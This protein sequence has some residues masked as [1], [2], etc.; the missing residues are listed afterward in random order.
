MLDVTISDT[1][2]KEADG[3]WLITLSP[4]FCRNPV[5]IPQRKTVVDAA[6]V[7]GGKAIMVLLSD[8]SWGIWDPEGAGPR[9]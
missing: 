5:G 4:E 7:L 9:S 6:W 8:G 3:A 1:D 2:L